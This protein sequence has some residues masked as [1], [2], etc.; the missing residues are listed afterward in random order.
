MYADDTTLFNSIDQPKSNSQQRQHLCEVLN[1]DLEAI[2]EWDSQLIVS[3]NSKT[4]SILH[5]RRKGDGVQYDFKM[6]NTFKRITLPLL[7]L[8]IKSE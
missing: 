6:S 5:S 7:G 4:Q 1:K 8:N 2:S 3:F